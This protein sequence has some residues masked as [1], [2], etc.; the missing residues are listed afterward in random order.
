[1]TQGKVQCGQDSGSVMEGNCVRVLQRHRPIRCLYAY[2][3]IYYEK[4]AYT[5]MEQRS[6]KVCSLPPKDPGEPLM[7][8]QP[9]SK[10]PR[11]RRT[12]VEDP[13]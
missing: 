9:K 3:E 1:M 8:L 4:L 5:M 10:G 11:L 12:D 6:P 2:K 7:W 13:A